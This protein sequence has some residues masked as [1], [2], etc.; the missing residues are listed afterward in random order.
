MEVISIFLFNVIFKEI[1]LLF[2]CNLQTLYSYYNFSCT[3]YD[4]LLKLYLLP[5]FIDDKMTPYVSINKKNKYYLTILICFLYILFWFDFRLNVNLRIILESLY[6]VFNKMRKRC[7]QTIEYHSIGI[8]LP[9]V[10]SHKLIFE[11]LVL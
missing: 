6:R 5:D 2:L 10:L 8:H 4:T 7:L 1:E 3:L 9:R 11:S